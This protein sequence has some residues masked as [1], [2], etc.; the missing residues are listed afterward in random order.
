MM[1]RIISIYYVILFFTAFILMDGCKAR[2]AKNNVQSEFSA[3]DSDSVFVSLNR[4]PCFGMCPT[5]KFFL[6]QNGYAL[7]KGKMEVRRIGTYEAHF[8]KEQM[9]MFKDAAMQDRV[10]TLQSE[11]VNLQI[12]DFPATYSSIVLNGKRHTFHVSTDTPPESLT[13]FEKTVERLLEMGD[14]KKISDTVKDE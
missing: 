10:D 13:H 4:F 1:K 11:Y 14:W 7:Y 5:Y 6:Y 2:T 3:N 12:A 9:R 8:T